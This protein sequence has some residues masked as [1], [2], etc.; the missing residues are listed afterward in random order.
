MGSSSTCSGASLSIT[1][2]G[3]S[4]EP[5]TSLSGASFSALK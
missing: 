2:S 4:L 5:P 3:S 1:T